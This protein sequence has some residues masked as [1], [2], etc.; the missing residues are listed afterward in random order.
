MAMNFSE[1]TLNSLGDQ[2]L[3]KIISGVQDV[4]K[5]RHPGMTDI[6]LPGQKA[7][8]RESQVLRIALCQQTY[9]LLQHIV[10][11]RADEKE[12]L[13]AREGLVFLPVTSQSYAQVVAE[14]PAHFWEN[15]LEWANGRL[16]LRDYVPPVA[17]EV[18][19]IEA[20][21]ALPGSFSRPR[22]VA[23]EMIEWYSR[24]LQ[25][26]FPDFRAVMLPVT[27]YASTDRAYA[28]RNPGQVLFKNYFAWALDDLSGVY[29]ASA[30]RVAPDDQFH[31]L[32][33]SAGPG[34]ECVGA[35]PAVV[36][37]GNK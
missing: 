26:E 22:D 19:L 3:A 14:D 2:D 27:G 20:Q 16:V 30:G 10:E 8:S 28:K 24:K 31:V 25:T 35:V 33:W 11:P 13:K 18:G 15:E 37:I 1:R 17:V 5:K 6:P 32:G 29:A 7:S 12:V 9:E 36:K 23:W 21:L 4:F 34:S